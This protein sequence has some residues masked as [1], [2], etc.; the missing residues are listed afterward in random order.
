M[1][2]YIAEGVGTLY[3]NNPFFVGIKDTKFNEIRIFRGLW[4]Y[5]A[6]VYINKQKS[7]P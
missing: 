2:A 4:G 3:L 6:V 5:F 1:T 7:N